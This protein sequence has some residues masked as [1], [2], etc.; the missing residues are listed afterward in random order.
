MVNDAAIGKQAIGKPPVKRRPGR[1]RM[2]DSVAY[3]SNDEQSDKK[4]RTRLAQRS[5]RTR[6]QNALLSTKT[7]AET[8]EAA[9][10]AVLNEFIKFHD[11]A[12]QRDRE[13]SSD[14]RLQLSKTATNMMTIA[15]KAQTEPTRSLNQPL[16]S[17]TSSFDSEL[18]LQSI[19]TS[20][21]TLNHLDTTIAVRQKEPYFSPDIYDA[22]TQRYLHACLRR[23]ANMLRLEKSPTM[24][25]LPAMLL[26]LQLDHIDHLLARVIKLLSMPERPVTDAPYTDFATRMLPRMFRVIDGHLDT[27]VPR[28]SP[29]HLQRLKFGKT[30]TVLQTRIPDL[31]GMWLEATDVEEYLQERGI[32]VRRDLMSDIVNLSASTALDLSQDMENLDAHSNDLDHAL[33]VSPYTLTSLSALE[34]HYLSGDSHDKWVEQLPPSFKESNPD[35]TIFGQQHGDSQ[36]IPTGVQAF[37]LP[38][39][40]WN[41]GNSKSIAAQ[42]I[43]ITINLSK[44]IQGLANAAI[45]LGPCPGIQRAN[46]D[47]AIRHAV[48]GKP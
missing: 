47:E 35:F 10:D 48:V 39:K 29:P 6:K 3:D 33:N 32:F 22:F 12:T 16:T 15:R 46:V 8:L 43:Q 7:R 42:E 36:E 20:T 17:S 28:S 13:M 21:L 44:L 27:A 31:Q 25:L 23:A 4:S 14:I 11:V 26:P 34:R 5:Y 18:S 40:F 2:N 38:Q 45:C 24:C 9:L 37:A 1:P 30:R 41:Q 19:D